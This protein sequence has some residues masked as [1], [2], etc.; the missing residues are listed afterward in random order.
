M[1]I[2]YYKFLSFFF[3]LLNQIMIYM[4]ETY[5]RIFVTQKSFKV[6]NGQT[7]KNKG[8]LHLD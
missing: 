7:K 2:I 6:L 3:I 8:I 5:K 1:Y 4:C